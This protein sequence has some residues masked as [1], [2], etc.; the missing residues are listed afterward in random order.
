MN[1]QI[2]LFILRINVGLAFSIT[3]LFLS[4]GWPCIVKIPLY[5]LSLCLH[6]VD[7]E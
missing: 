7:R 6:A 5:I 1:E 4:A 3:A 2:T